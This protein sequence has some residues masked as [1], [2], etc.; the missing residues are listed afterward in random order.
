MSEEFNLLERFN[1][2]EVPIAEAPKKK[3]KKTTKPADIPTKKDKPDNTME[4][5]FED[6]EPKGDQI[7][8]IERQKPEEKIKDITSLLNPNPPLHYNLDDF[9]TLLSND[10][11]KLKHHITKADDGSILWTEIYCELGPEEKFIVFRYNDAEVFYIVEKGRGYMLY[12]ETNSG[13]AMHERGRFVVERSKKHVV[14][15]SEEK[16]WFIFTI[17]VQGELDFTSIPATKQQLDRM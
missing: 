10:R 14:N 17:M 12:T 15:N 8:V 1:P 11:I 9:E 13:H 4:Q 3:E 2:N 16:D 5:M 7:E 6:I